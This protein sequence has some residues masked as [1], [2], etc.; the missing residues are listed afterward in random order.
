MMNNIA[1]TVESLLL[2]NIGKSPL[3][4][5]FLENVTKSSPISQN[6]FILN[7]SNCSKLVESDFAEN[8]VHASKHVRYN[9]R[10]E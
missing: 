3:L 7:A 9:E 2:M 6:L 8:P 1:S 10:L 5:T 4:T